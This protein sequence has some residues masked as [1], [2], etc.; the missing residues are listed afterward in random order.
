MS[1][2]CKK[3]FGKKSRRFETVQK[4]VLLIRIFDGFGQTNRNSRRFGTN[5]PEPI[6]DGFFM[7]CARLVLEQGLQAHVDCAALKLLL[8]AFFLTV[9]SF[10]IPH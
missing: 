9:T 10:F 8:E 6:L 5:R 3:P 2:N 1:R 7:A 4:N